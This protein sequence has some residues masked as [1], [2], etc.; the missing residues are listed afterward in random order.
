MSEIDTF[1]GEIQHLPG[2]QATNDPAALRDYA[3]DGVLPRLVVTPG[4][5]EEVASVIALTSQYGLT[6][7]ARG[8][9]S[10]M[11][12]GAI[13]EPFVVLIETGKLTRLLEHEAPDL[14]C[15]VEA[16]ITLA[17]P[18]TPTGAQSHRVPLG[19]PRTPPNTTVGNPAPSS[20]R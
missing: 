18:P 3:I 6:T 2:I 19:P 13:P 8:G 12:L 11:H 16:G 17:G 14:T 10:R 20:P 15:Q 7:L 9:G 5:A 4:S 1:I